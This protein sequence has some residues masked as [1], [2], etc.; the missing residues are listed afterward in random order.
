MAPV[1]DVV[2]QLTSTTSETRS[3]LFRSNDFYQYY[4]NG[5]SNNSISL[6]YT[7]ASSQNLDLDLFVYKEVHDLN[8]DS[9][10][11]LSSKLSFPEQGV[12]GVETVNFS[13]LPAGYYL[14]R[15]KAF[16]TNL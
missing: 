7:Q 8:E 2:F 12:N 3:H 15:V 14:V 16:T 9:G 11:V 4:H 13:G 1:Q 10:L 5:Q 6:K